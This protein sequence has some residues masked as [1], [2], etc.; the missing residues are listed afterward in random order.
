M[1]YKCLLYF[2]CIS[3]FTF[4]AR[5][6]CHILKQSTPR[7]HVWLGPRR[8]GAWLAVMS[9]VCM[10]TTTETTS[11]HTHPSQ[12]PHQQFNKILSLSMIRT[13][14][15]GIKSERSLYLQAFI[16]REKSI[17]FHNSFRDFLSIFTN[18]YLHLQT[19]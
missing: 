16:Y 15:P 2:L 14:I 19:V 18:R 11:P 10:M 6:H 5:S 13:K 17:D 9:H 8:T 4:F 7:S 3:T 12:R 1:K